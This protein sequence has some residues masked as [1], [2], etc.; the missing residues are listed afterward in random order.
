MK[1]TFARN[2]VLKGDEA[3]QGTSGTAR[4]YDVQKGA[5]VNA[6]MIQEDIS[7]GQRI[8]S[9]LVEAYK[10]GAWIHLSE[11][12]TV[13][14]KRLVRFS[15]TRPER[16]RVTIRSARGIANVSAVVCSMPNLLLIKVRKC[17]LVTSL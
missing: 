3:W 17:S 4:E 15:D 13:G 14:Y 5:L 10:D 16:I 2:Y 1:K 12:T 9:F 8:E 7:K 11:G 6:F